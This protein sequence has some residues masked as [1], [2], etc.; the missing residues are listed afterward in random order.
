MAFGTGHHDTTWMMIRSLLDL[1]ISGSN[2]LDMGCGTGVLAIAAQK[3]GAC[4]VLAIDIEDGAVRNTIENAAL[5]SIEISD[6]FKVDCGTSELL[7]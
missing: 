1:N 2:V 4:S 6:N 5:N 3:L 7:T